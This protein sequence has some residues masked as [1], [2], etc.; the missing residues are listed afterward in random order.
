MKRPANPPGEV[1]AA[2]RA[3]LR[4]RAIPRPASISSRCLA[5]NGVVCRTCEEICEPGAVSFIM[6]IGAVAQPHIELD[7]CTRC[8][9]CA[10]ACPAGA[11]IIVRDAEH[12]HVA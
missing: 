12:G 6:R 8:G 9:D 2:R 4:G 7:T 5:L 10:P 1:D 11:I 3:F